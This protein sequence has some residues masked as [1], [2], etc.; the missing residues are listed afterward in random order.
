MTA[1]ASGS[2]TPSSPTSSTTRNAPRCRDEPC[3]QT[4]AANGGAT[5][6]PSTRARPVFVIAD[7]M[8]GAQAGEVASQIAVEA[9][10]QRVCPSAA[11]RGAPRRRRPASESRDP[12]ALPGR[13]RER[14]YGDHPHRRLSRRRLRS[15]SLTSA[16]AAPTCCRD[17]ELTRLTEDHSLVEELLR[18]GKLTEEEALEH[19][20]RSMITRALG[21]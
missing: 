8:G 16:T 17:G 14:R 10:V 6:T 13:A 5:R 18:G 15:R 20:Q 12:R 2:A 1:T 11:R 3:A 19:P 7:G 21:T 9:F 4:R